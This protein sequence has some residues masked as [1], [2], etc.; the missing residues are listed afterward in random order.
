MPTYA[1]RY[2]DTMM[3]LC[4]FLQNG[5]ATFSIFGLQLLVFLLCN[6]Q[7]SCY[8]WFPCKAFRAGY[9]GFSG[10]YRH[11]TA[12]RDAW[13]SRRRSHYGNATHW[14]PPLRN[15]CTK[16]EMNLVL[17]NDI[18]TWIVYQLDQFFLKSSR[19]DS[20]LPWYGWV[21]GVFWEKPSSWNRRWQLR[22]DKEIPNF[23]EM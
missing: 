1:I 10:F 15:K 17:R 12:K 4:I 20:S 16:H 5:D 19:A 9:K 3:R 18:C 11:K 14:K 2:W 22:T 21:C 8:R 6:K 23:L 7:D 13:F